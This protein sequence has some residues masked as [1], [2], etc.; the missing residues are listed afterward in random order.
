MELV[1]CA[2]YAVWAYLWTKTWS[3]TIF[4]F[5][6][7]YTPLHTVVRVA[8]AATS[9][10]PYQ[11]TDA[12]MTAG[13]IF[14]PDLAILLIL[15]MT[16]IVACALAILATFYFP[17]PTRGRVRHQRH[18]P[19]PIQK[20]LV[21]TAAEWA[22]QLLASI[23]TAIGSMT[24]QRRHRQCMCHR[25]LSG[26]TARCTAM[27]RAT[28]LTRRGTAVKWRSA[29]RST[30]VVTKIEA[31][32]DR[33]RQLLAMAAAYKS[34]HGGHQF[35]SDSKLMAIDNCCSKCITND[36]HD[37]IE[38]PLEVN[39]RV[40]GVG[41]TITATL[42]G[43]VRWTIEDDNGVVHYQ[44]IPGTYYNPNS[45]YKL[46][47][48]QHVAQVYKDHYPKPH[49]TWCATYN[50]SVVL[51]WDQCKF[52][53]TVPLDKKTNVALIRT[54]AGYQ[55][56]AAFCH[57]V[58]EDE[59]LVAFSHTNQ[60][61]FGQNEPEYHDEQIF[62]DTVS[63]DSAQRRHPNLPDEAF[64]RDSDQRDGHNIDPPTFDLQDA[65]TAYEETKAQMLEWHC[66][67]GHLPF[68][69]IQE[70][71]KRGDLPSKFAKCSP[72]ICGACLYAKK[73]RKPWRG[74]PTSGIHTR[75][76][77]APGDMVAI[78]QM[79]SPTPGLVAQMKGFLTKQR[80][81]AA[82][83]FVDHF[84]NLSFTYFQKGLTIAETLEAK[85]AFER[86]AAAHGVTIK[87][88][89]TDNGIF[90][91]DSFRTS[92]EMAGKTISYAGV[93]AHHQNGHAEGKIR[94]LQA[95]G[96][97]MLLH[98]AHR[99]PA[100]ITA[101]LWPYA[102]RM[103]NDLINSSPQVAT[104]QS[105]MER[106]TQVDVAPRVRH[107]HTFGC[108]VYV[109]DAQLQTAGGQIDKWKERSRVGL[110]L[111][112]SPRHSKR[113]ALV[114]N[115]QTGHVSPQFH[116]TFDDN[117]ETI[118]S[119][120]LIPES[121]WQSKTGFR[122]AKAT[123]HQDD[124]DAAQIPSSEVLFHPSD[125]P[126]GTPAAT[127]EAGQDNNA[128]H[129]ANPPEPEAT[130]R[131]Q[132]RS[133][134]DPPRPDEPTNPL[135]QYT[136]RS[137]RRTVPTTRWLESQ[138]Q[139]HEDALALTVTWEVFHDGGY[140][141]QREMD[142]PIAF[143][144]SSET[145]LTIWDKAVAMA[146][147]SSP[148]VMYMD[149]ALREPDG[150][151][152]RKAMVDEVAA[153][154]DN[155]HWEIVPRSLVPSGTK[156]L[157]AV[158]A[159]RRK[160]RLAT[161]EPYKWKARL[162]VRGGKQEY[163]VNYWETYAPVIAWDTI[164]LFLVLSLLNKWHTRQIDFV[165][166]YPQ[167]DIECP[168]YMDIPSQLEYQGSRKD[169]CL[170]L[171]KNLYGQKQAGRVWNQ[172]LHDRLLARGFKQSAVDMCLYYRKDVALLIY[173]DDGILIGPNPKDL[174]AII[175]LLKAPVVARG[176]QTHRAFNITDE[177]TLDEY[178][179]VKVEHLPNGTIKLSQPQLIQQI[180][181]DLG[182]NGRTTTK[183]SPAASTV[184]LHR[185]LGRC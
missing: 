59:P 117:F 108:P 69:K 79:V 180:L 42:C 161:G 147:S 91:T 26:N 77:A 112:A 177:G 81:T 89:Q 1:I 43:T 129:E 65:P 141:T 3:L 143:L 134:H 62:Q 155:D 181:D 29:H 36:L 167:A 171:K 83:V 56:F 103:A 179:G 123:V 51:Q 135:N 6:Y 178:L 99:W 131:D 150:E 75:V 170:L 85:A 104:G 169:H 14:L 35:D 40:Q 39:T 166:A 80:Y 68:N 146:A 33:D 15:A 183:D 60:T 8:R 93:N 61:D 107:S 184:R 130:N 113:V 11:A 119:G 16:V 57:T 157:P 95:M 173:T 152:F 72:P 88:Y 41:G 20:W 25:R 144:G 98:A 5:V 22:T 97:A 96:R 185:D 78:D 52:T 176:K 111:G 174:D 17:A 45:E 137:G 82:T 55:K 86:Y 58:C 128:H 153:H 70:L 172:Y 127:P 110:Y 145:V 118:R 114:L 182:L 27:A 162:N 149:Q 102:V 175:A 124:S 92:V 13:A 138:Q 164:R 109:L 32:I 2:L 63:P 54:A 9:I 37:Y 122:K 76:A 156:V 139:Q 10:T 106:F 163:G 48:P 18:D 64:I 12:V 84:S 19:S 132:A 28:R 24:T 121:L 133:A 151:Q 50:D 136:T 47:S 125:R 148:D 74:R 120:S 115:L 126:N 67:L 165:L 168:I 66:R 90:E 38:P 94:D 101:N 30:S 23:E 140:D 142:D 105:P 158:W 4:N 7:L 21:Q 34:P 71:A 116:V 87:H 100:A 160:R 49:G 73:T 154:T 46:Y 53:R 31:A 44:T 159:M